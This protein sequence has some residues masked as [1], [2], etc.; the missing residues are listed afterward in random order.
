M[1]RD[2]R[3][4][5]KEKEQQQTEAVVEAEM[6]VMEAAQAPEELNYLGWLAALKTSE[7]K[8]YEDWFT[9][10]M[11]PIVGGNEEPPVKSKP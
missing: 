1:L 9:Q 7:F 2:Q 5:Q 3:R 10:T 6:E 4:L 8:A 11:L